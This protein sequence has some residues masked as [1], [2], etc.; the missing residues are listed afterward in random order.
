M[1]TLNKKAMKHQINE[2]TKPSDTNPRQFDSHLK[3]SDIQ[4]IFWTV[5]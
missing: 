5:Q 2:I 3:S 4:K 1:Y